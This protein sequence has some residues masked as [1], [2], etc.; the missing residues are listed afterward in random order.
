MLGDFTAEQIEQSAS[1]PLALRQLL[2]PIWAQHDDWLWSPAY[3]D[4][5]PA[6]E[7]QRIRL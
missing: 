2:Q 5:L 6:L 7:M 4:A 3:L 1:G